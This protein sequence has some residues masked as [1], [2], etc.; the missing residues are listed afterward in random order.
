MYEECLPRPHPHR[1]VFICI[2][3]QQ[4]AT[5]WSVETWVGPVTPSSKLGDILV[6]CT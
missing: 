5:F 3:T 1:F 6:H 4:N 2:M